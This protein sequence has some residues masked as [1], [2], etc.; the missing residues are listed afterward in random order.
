MDGLTPEPPQLGGKFLYIEDNPV[1]ALL[2]TEWSRQ[3]QLLELWVV[4]T[5]AQGIDE[6]ERKRPDLV[7]LDMQLPDMDGVEVIQA[8]RSTSFGASMPIVV[9]S[10]SASRED[11]LRA[12]DAGASAYWLKPVDFRQIEAD[13][14]LLLGAGTLKDR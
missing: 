10:A 9:L 14:R 4:A 5:A 11:M 1:N 13:L 8:V 2:M 12:R 7:L 6:V 3:F